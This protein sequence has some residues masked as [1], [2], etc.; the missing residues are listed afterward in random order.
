[1]TVHKLT[2]GD[3]Y[4]YLT[5]QVAAHDA[6]N[7]G[8]DNLG[9]YYSE[10]GEA[11]GVWMGRGL[12]AVPDFPV[13]EH[14][15]E[16]QMKALFGEGR[17]PNA[18]LIER[19]LI[20]QGAHKWVVDQ[21]TRLGSPYLVYEATQMF[22]RRTAGAFRDYN[23]ALGLHA[24]NPV[25]PDE[26]A[27]MR[28]EIARKMFIEEFGREPAD[29]RELSGHLAR[30]S[31]QQTTAVAGYDLTFSPVKSVSTL[32]AIAP[33]EVAD[34]IEQAHRDAVKDT[35][36]WIEDNAAYTRVGRHG[37]AQVETRG[38]LAAAFTHRDS[39]AGDPDL[40]THVAI[41]NK[42]QTLSGRW[43]AL[44]GRP[45]F[46]NNVPASERYNTRL[47]ALLI[48]RLGVR[49]A[50]RPGDDPTKRP[51]REI[52]GIDGALPRTWSSR[53]AAIDVRRAEL[54]AQF[55]RDHDRPPTPKE[56]VSLAQQANLETRQ[57]KHEPRSYADQRATWREEAVTVLGGE[58]QLGR[59]LSTALRSRAER[60][61]QHREAHTPTRAWI[62]S[63]A[64][65]VLAIVSGDR[66]TWQ[67]NHVRAEAERQ[68]RAAGI[69]LADLDKAVDAVVSDALSPARTVALTT[70]DNIAE[71]DLLR[72]SDGTSIYTAAGSAL[73]T[74]PAILTA[75]RTILTAA[76]QRGGRT[77]TEAAIDL[78]LVE[79]AAN[80]VTLNPG[81][82]QLVRQLAT[83][84]CH[85]QLALAPAGTGKTTAMRVLSCAWTG[86]GGNVIG[87]A[88]SAAAAAVLR[89]E[90]D[91]DTD[92]LAKLVWHLNNPA[93][94]PDWM[95]A[96][97][98]NTL[99]VID[100]A[101]MANT[102]DLADA[103]EHI[104]GRGGSVRL[105]GDD[106]QLA[107]IGAGGVLR[108]IAAEHGTV[109]LSQ[110]M[111]FTN[112][113]T[114]TPNHAEGAASLALRDGDTAGIAYYLDHGRIHVGDLTTCTDDAYTAWAA[115]R[116]NG[117]DSIMLA[118]TREL[119]SEL[120]NRAR[121]DRI[122]AGEVDST[123]QVRLLDNSR[124]SAG[125]T[126][127]TR[128]NNR[129]IPITATDWVKN[130]DRWRVNA[131]LE[132]G[133]LDV[134]HLR[135]GRHITLPADYVREHVTL[136]YASTVHGAQ[137]ITA[138][139]CHT[140][141][142]GE[143][144]RQLIYVAMTRGRYANHIYLTTAGDGDPHSVITP[145]AVLPP[146]AGDILARVLA[147]DAAP[148][149]ATTTGRDLADPLARLQI[150]ADRYHHA[151][152]TAAEDRLGPDALA[153]IDTAAESYINGITR[154]DAYPTL[155]AHLALLAVDGHDPADVLIHAA[156]GSRGLADAR[157]V[158]AVLDWRL[159][160]TGHRSAGTG[161]L[162]WLPGIPKALADDEDWSDYLAQRAQL[163]TGLAASV[164]EQARTWTPSSAPLWAQPLLDRDR[165]L[166]ADIA[167]W[168]AANA[169]DD[170]DR[171]PT[172]A[173]LPA[174]AEART[175]RALDQRVTAVLGDPR[176]TTT[177][178]ADLANGV[179]ERLTKDP[180]WPT[181][182]DRLTAAERAGIDI[183]TLTRRV[184]ADGPL[185]DEQPAA[186]L[187]WR[188]A[189]HLS[190]AAVTGR[191]HS[192]S[193]SL[194]PDWTPALADVLGDDAAAR[195]VADPA[196]PSLVAAVTHA[197]SAGWTPEQILDTAHQLL[198]GGQPDDEPLRENELATAL[199]WR[200][201]ILTDHTHLATAT[202]SSSASA[203]G[204]ASSTN[205]P[206]HDDIDTLEP[207]AELAHAAD[208]DWLA[209]LIEPTDADEP[210]PPD[211]YEPAAPP[212]DL[213]PA[214]APHTSW[215]AEDE[216][217]GA[218]YQY[219]GRAGIPRAR[220]IDLNQQAADFYADR[221]PT[222]WAATYLRDRLGT[223][224]TD[225]ARFSVGYAP[226]RWD[227]LTNHL[228][229]VGATDEEII[230]AGLGVR[231]DT[232]RVRD[233]FRD[234]LIFP[235]T[236]TAPDDSIEI[237]GFIGRRNPRK[238]DEDR[239][240]PKYLN[241]AETD[242]FRK[243]HEMYGIADQHAG[244]TAGGRPV[245]VEGPVDAIA[246]TLAGDGHYVG[247]AP[248][249][250]AFTDVQADRLNPYRTGPNGPVIVA[251]DADTAGQQAA[252]RAFWQLAVRGHN[253]DHVLVP[254]GKDPAELY[255]TSGP[256]A[257][258]AALENA[259]CLGD[260]VIAMRTAPFADRLD[261]VEGRIHA[262]RRAAQVVV[263]LPPDQWA[264]QAQD[265]AEKIGVDH[266]VAIRE[267]IDASTDW[268]NDSHAQARSHAGD[269]LPALP[270]A[271]TVST[272]DPNTRWADLVRT[273]ADGVTADPEW[274]ALAAH[275]THAADTGFNV[276]SRLPL[277]VTDKPLDPEHRA[278]D[279]D[280][281]L[282]DAWPACLPH[283][284]PEVVQD[285]RT[286][287]AAA[288]TRARMADSDRLHAN[289]VVRPSRVRATQTQSSQ[290]DRP[291]VPT[292]EH[293]APAPQPQDRR[294]G[295]RR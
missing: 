272:T 23:T 164:D 29:A 36:T 132:S 285:N 127:I 221:Y 244:L 56:A 6:T 70:H 42:V 111:R 230:A 51:V 44:D 118:P 144:S 180:Y 140:V 154:A 45:I 257:L 121:A 280:F 205:A 75:E 13:G 128:R 2:A 47:E 261:T 236:A 98:P 264:D 83:S 281:R 104:T 78:Q 183:T 15:T 253:P 235:I 67:P 268:S 189:S 194:R 117:L 124:A 156:A 10:K 85:V 95:A 7:R 69:R 123:R 112:P 100:E 84:G 203:S 73:Y 289:K 125:D 147:R 278:R 177:R 174:A 192:G 168:R 175:Q 208:E 260:H 233:R 213:P 178:W 102:A 225:D 113:E 119:V 76:A 173:S 197:G 38:L 223:D 265:L 81:Q 287:A 40:H 170:S 114:G 207:L 282:I 80:G 209:S 103:I 116:T 120:N 202:T 255:Q 229:S 249:G 109:T 211:P 59:Y 142:S 41:S 269:R 267:I 187:W 24:D 27:R 252:Y 136:G 33:K 290:P 214:P 188:L 199:V 139:T 238:S 158:A 77:I 61:R 129:R 195:V 277:L 1:M 115:D 52:V 89:E 28:S 107:A 163:V 185:P 126:I 57:R 232:G 200:I 35:L 283:P 242:L 243:G 204:T 250:T 146:T 143:E 228:R 222:S 266:H 68:A 151:L 138:D 206:V 48:D 39:R 32:W 72:R 74:S 294:A 218:L 90:I 240:G 155:R 58:T 184:A 293:V 190:P 226:D 153:A 288:T 181:L 88:P 145:D 53:R 152:A 37:V 217:H 182:A 186:S 216:D 291:A 148:I 157:D 172:G 108:D 34:V 20:R 245:L 60:R 137:G 8:Y 135:T 5:R 30:I 105:I 92:T 279:L 166:V 26:R 82:D 18:D 21:S 16:A 25:P 196:W 162:P 64:D 9:A 271:A 141:G 165:N 274:P 239:C 79:S 212:T 50:D 215:V 54:S 14:V 160:P 167:V 292:P 161:P 91:T 295:P 22:N 66:A 263:A 87:L 262:L 259:G 201:A 12:A 220:L 3:G 101:G 94:A 198:V 179:D 224:L 237:H 258:R 270:P 122:A 248:L 193:D 159:D 110:V 134:T 86:S 275:L 43:L 246:V 131:V 169:V 234:R 63:T 19:E 149:S 65:K 286:T 241:T 254:H 284:V 219:P 93:G 247:V 171:R 97:G 71:P 231:A 276:E 273:I 191:D 210:A 256:A 96:I 106:Q 11:P 55:Q 49:F 31:R 176:A 133:S 4:T 251:T 130:G 227:T 99:V 17:H 150:A 62:S 46:K